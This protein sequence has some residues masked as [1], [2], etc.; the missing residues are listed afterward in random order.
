MSVVAQGIAGLVRSLDSTL[1]FISIVVGTLFGWWLAKSRVSSAAAGVLIPLTGVVVIIIQVGQ[2]GGKLLALVQ[3]LVLL[4]QQVRAG[5]SR[6]PPHVDVDPTPVL[7]VFAELGANL[8][9][10]LLR[11]R[12]WLGSLLGSRA[13]FDPVAAAIVWSLA[14]WGVASWAAWSVRRRQET[15]QGLMPALGLLAA[16]F[17]YTGGD[18]LTLIVPMFV[19]L[20]LMVVVS[21]G[22]REGRWRALRM[23]YS[24]DIRLDMAIVVTP[25]CVLLLLVAWFVPSISLQ[26]LAEMT[27]Q[28]IAEPARQAQPLP[29]SLGLKPQSRPLPAT[30]ALRAPGLPRSHLIGSGPELSQEIV[31]VI[32]TGDL[33]PMPAPAVNGLPVQ[34]PPRYYWRSS[35]YDRYT[36]AGWITGEPQT[37]NYSAGQEAISPTVRAQRLVR[38][39]VKLNADV[40]GLVYIAGTLLATDQ[41]YRIA[42]RTNNDAFNAR[43]ANPP[44]T[45]RADSLISVASEEQL[46]SVPADYPDWVRERYLQLPDKMPER[47][48]SLARDLTATGRTPYDRAVA[49]ES[50]LRTYSY[51]LDLPAPPAGRDVADYFLFD[52]KRGYCDYFSASMVVLARAAG[53]PARLVVGYASGAYDAMNAQYVVTQADAHSWPEIYFNEYGWVEFEPTS[54]RAAIERPSATKPVPTSGVALPPLTPPHTLISDLGAAAPLILIAFLMLALPAWYV[55]DLWRLRQMPPRLVVNRLF[56]RLQTQGRRLTVP[57]HP[58][59]TPYEYTSALARRVADLA[60]EERRQTMTESSARELSQLAELYVRSSYSPYQPDDIDRWHALRLWR[61]LNVRLWLAWLWQALRRLQLRR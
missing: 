7:A 3:M 47:V 44:E 6:L 59:D 54:G 58:G 30:D 32:S 19:L 24:E 41:D 21:H 1:L 42:W 55:A 9:T 15:L 23:D 49:I 20:A 33:P 13:A 28:A 8:L 48:V 45:Y 29:D 5:L 17:A 18:A 12:D 22:A 10:L 57:T 37:L 51:T 39:Q 38:Q 27:Q 26:Q 60:P 35:T 11:V 53:L 34:A 43:F 2:L 56:E 31:M 25:L 14:L 4:D 36:G 52:L 16:A 50:Y 40:G 46:R 61:R